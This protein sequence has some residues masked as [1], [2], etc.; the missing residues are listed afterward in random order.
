M[1]YLHTYSEVSSL[2][3]VPPLV[4]LARLG[5][6]V[7]PGFVVVPKAYSDFLDYAGLRPA[8]GHLASATDPSQPDQ[9]LQQRNSLYQVFC[10][11]ALP[12]QLAREIFGACQK[13][14]SPVS[15]WPSIS[16]PIAGDANVLLHVKRLWAM[17]FPAE[18]SILIQQVLQPQASG[19]IHTPDKNHPPPKD[20]LSYHGLSDH[21]VR[22]LV[23]A[24]ELVRKHYYFSQEIS[25]TLSRGRI[26]ITASRP[27]TPPI[28]FASQPLLPTATKVYLDITSPLSSRQLTGTLADGIHVLHSDFLFHE[29]GIHPK[30]FLTRGQAQSFVD[31]LAAAL[32][33]YAQTLFPKPVVY[34]ASSLSTSQYRALTAG[35]LFELNEPNPLLGFR[36]GLR[37]LRDSRLFK[38]ELAAISSL[39]RDHHLT[40][41]HLQVAFVR[42]PA[43]LAAIQKLVTVSGLD[44]G[45][46]WLAAQTPANVLQLDQFIAAGLDGITI[47][48]ALLESLL[49]GMDRSNPEVA[50]TY[51]Q[52]NPALTY[53]LEKAIRSAVKQHIPCVLS[54]SNLSTDLIHSAVSWGV[55]GICVPFSALDRARQVVHSAES[56]WLKISQNNHF[57]LSSS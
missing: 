1:P 53:M 43:E 41:L 55:S 36:G 46:R 28:P 3:A 44:A 54:G 6:P 31:M 26:Y 2:D 29:I 30:Q 24:G 47:D 5:L 37:Y 11:T 50:Q 19:S 4:T 33:I 12:P 23:Q 10:K 9:L 35:D 42:L 52:P 49:L 32:F 22:Q 56:R 25:W 40:N 48:A 39:R 18:T 16:D 7:P 38:L 34:E 13:L 20:L 45:Q 8:V 14:G 15:F 17:H 21:H 51:S 57:P 27:A